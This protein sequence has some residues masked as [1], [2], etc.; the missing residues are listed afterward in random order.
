[1]VENKNIV[2]VNTCLSVRA[3][4]IIGF[5]LG[6][7]ITV[8]YVLLSP[9]HAIFTAG[10]VMII[11]LGATSFIDGLSKYLPMFM[12]WLYGTIVWGLAYLGILMINNYMLYG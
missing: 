1:M 5:L 4:V 3:Q 9:Y 7:I 10:A 2:E 6:Q 8:E 11:F 12:S